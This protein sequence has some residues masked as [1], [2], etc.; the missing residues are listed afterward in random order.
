MKTLFSFL[1]S[2]LTL[3]VLSQADFSQKVSNALKAGDA[4]TLASLC[5]DQVELSIGGQDNIYTRE[6]A[7]KQ[8]ASFFSRNVA[9]SFVIRHEGTSKLDCQYRIGELTTSTGTYRVTFF[10]KKN[11]TQMQVKQLKIEAPDSN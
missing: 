10:M 5:M 8:L 2:L 11:G 9:K 1:L 6:E 3:T 7:K 4:A